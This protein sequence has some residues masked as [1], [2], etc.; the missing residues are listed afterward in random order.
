[1]V[2]NFQKKARIPGFRPGKA[3]ASMIRRHFEGDIRQQVLESLVPK[4]FDSQVQQENLKVVGQ[5][6][7]VDVIFMPASRC[8]FKAE[9]EVVP[10]VELNDYRGMTGAVSK[11]LK[12]LTTMSPPASSRSATKKPLS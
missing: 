5:P 12:F 8:G 1:M 10:E 3:P 6:N 11:I 7:I 2:V 4:F 9:F